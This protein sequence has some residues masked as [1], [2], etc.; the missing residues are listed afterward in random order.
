LRLHQCG[1][2]KQMALEL[3]KPFVMKRL[4]D[5]N[6]AQNIKSAKRMVERATGGTARYAMVWDVLE[7]VITEHP[8]LLNR[9][10][11]LHRLGIQAFEPQLVE[12]K[13]I[14]IHP[15]VCTAFNAD[16]DGDQMAV[17]LPLSAEA[18]AEAR[19][20]MLSSNNILSP[21]HGRPITSPTQDMVLGLY[22]LTL[23]REDAK[24]QDRTFGSVA[25]AIMAY[26]TGELD[27]QARVKI[28]IDD[29]PAARDGSGAPGVLRGAETDDRPFTA[30]EGWEP[31]QPVLVETTLGR[32]LFNEAM[33]VDYPFVDHEVRKAQLGEIVNDLAERYPKVQ[34][35]ATLDALKEAGFH[36]ATRAGVTIAISDVVTPPEKAEIL[37]RYEEQAEKVQ[38]QYERGVITDDERRQELIEIWTRATTEVATR[39]RENFPKDNPIQMMVGSGARG[40]MLQVQQIAGM[41]GLVANPKGEIIP[42]PIKTNFREGLTV[43]EYFISTHGARK[44][45]ADTA[46]RTADSGYLTR[47]LV[48]VSQDVIVREVDC[49]T[50]RGIMVPI[51]LTDA[52][53]S[54]VLDRDNVETRVYARTL[55]EDV[56]VNKKVL[57][58]AGADLGDVL[59]AELVEQGVAE[60]RVRSVLTCDSK[61]GI[62]GLCYGRSLATGKTV[63]VGEAVGIIA[64]Q[65]IGEPGTQLTMRTF[66]TGG[67]AGEDITHGLPRVV[68]LFEARQPK[69]RAPISEVA[70][71]VSIVET[72]KSAN[73]VVTPDD[74]GE[75]HE[76]PLSKRMLSWR[77]YDAESERARGQWRV[78]EGQHVEVGD[79]L[80]AGAVDPH[81]VLRILGP[82]EVQLHLVKEVQDVYRSQGV[83]IHDKH[84]EIII[85]QMLKRVNILESGDTELLPGELAERPKFEEENRRVV[86]E[87]G[88]PAA[89]RPVLMGITKASLAT[90]SWLSAASFQETTRVLTDAAIHARSDSLLGLKE[91][92]IIGKL[93]PAGTGISRYRNVRVEPTE[94]AKA[95]VYTMMPYDDAGYDFGQGSG[96]AVPL[97][98]YGFGQRPQSGYGSDYGSY[99]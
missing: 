57:A 60:I 4:V 8:V 35:A 24:G 40:N 14:Q 47:R 82:R 23:M 42:R 56:V 26:D 73:F 7:E 84:I 12:G 85:R 29:L 15:L 74:G 99:R 13:A 54:L 86:A 90:E 53:G 81:E 91:N 20:L 93:I 36:W 31:G 72:D 3:F 61:V 62:C 49:G 59:I 77:W 50:D 67:V 96:E 17:H 41:R 38:K 76:Y 44:G 68:E 18:Q 98:D 11:T 37:A 87:G 33:P 97:E 46:L 94:E 19:I 64:A 6:H 45:L 25:E 21:A 27:L 1:L 39:M 92:V 58:K 9:A 16:F 34:V 75:P 83:T 66:H 30:P 89:G 63:D 65:S 5:L 10:P 52:D 88:T 78:E 79:Q 28:R 22:Y 70:G 51:A 43:L 69:G 55:A 48:D 80:H 32:C 2:P 95:A 71:R